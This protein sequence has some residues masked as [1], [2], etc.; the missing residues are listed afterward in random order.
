MTDGPLL[1]VRGGA[2]G[3][4]VLTLPVLAAC[5]ATGRRVDVAC[6]RRHRPLVEAVGRPHRL[7]DLDGA[8]ALWMFGGRDP[9]GYA[10]A[11]VFA[12]AR[13]DLPGPVCHAVA[14]RPAPGVT[15]AA[16]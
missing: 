9:V 5:F 4:F 7:W 10:E 15:A 6:A 2:L 13:A 3:D 11:V 12:G 14:A 8:E 16:H 1:F